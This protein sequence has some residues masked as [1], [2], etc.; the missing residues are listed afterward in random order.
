MLQEQTSQMKEA[1]ANIGLVL[2]K[3]SDVLKHVLTHSERK[4]VSAFVQSPQDSYAPQSGEIFGILNQ[5]KE[6]F[7]SNLAAAQKDETT[8]HKGFADLKIAKEKEIK[9]GQ[10]M[11]NKKTKELA[12][13]DEKNAEAKEDLADTKKTLS[14]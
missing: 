3:H 5:M 8:N 10:K 2:Q 7:E 9:S 11:I 6:T 14:A 4:L 1:A 13:T 12:T